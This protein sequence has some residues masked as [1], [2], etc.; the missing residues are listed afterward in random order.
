MQ[1][2]FSEHDI[3]LIASAV[4]EK[5]KPILASV[6][7]VDD[8]NEIFD[9]KSLAEYLKVS[10]SLINQLVSSRAIPHFKLSKGKSGGVRFQKK[11]IDSWIAKQ[12]APAINLSSSLKQI[13][14][15]RKA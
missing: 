13:S 12:T 8:S 5:L 2:Q 4:A 9:K 15:G 10:V 11:S 1:L 14:L 6:K 3:D 7:P